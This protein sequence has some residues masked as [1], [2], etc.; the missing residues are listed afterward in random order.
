MAAQLPAYLGMGIP[1]KPH[2]A[3]RAPLN[4]DLRFR[5][6]TGRVRGGAAESRA[7]LCGGVGGKQHVGVGGAQST[8]YDCPALER[9]CGCG[10]RARTLAVLAEFGFE[11]WGAPRDAEGAMFCELRWGCQRV[12]R[13]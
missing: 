6:R 8:E 10:A 9:P 3:L 1:S 4:S 7:T 2:A 11:G 13:S 12:R 5:P